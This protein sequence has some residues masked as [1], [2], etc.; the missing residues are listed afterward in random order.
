MKIKDIILEYK[1]AYLYHTTDIF[2]AIR[3]WQ[4]D[5]LRGGSGP[6]DGKT[7]FSGASTTRNYNYALGYLRGSHY[8]SGVIFWL[9]QDLIKQ[10][11]GRRRLR[12]YDW[13]V[14]AE[15]NTLNVDANRRDDFQDT[16]RFET[17]ITKGGLTPFRKYVAKMEVWLPRTHDRLPPQP[18][19]RPWD[20]AANDT[21]NPDKWNTNIR[22]DQELIDSW[23]KDPMLRGAWEAMKRDPRTDIKTELGKPSVY[24]GKQIEPKVQFNTEHPAYD[25]SLEYD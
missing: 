15:P 8:Y 16:D 23:L 13:F 22:I 21:K 9:N 20:R 11:I 2:S 14:D 1:E 18:N 12:G 24:Q 6:S 10:D 7:K 3:I 17:V 25:A 5:D 19:E 4:S